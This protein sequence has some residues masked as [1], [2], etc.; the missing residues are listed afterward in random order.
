MAINTRV[1]LFIIF[2]IFSHLILP[3]Y[4]GTWI[5]KKSMP[6]KRSDISAGSFDDKI[7]IAGGCDT[8]QKCPIDLEFCFCDSVSIKTEAYLPDTDEWVTLSNMPQ[9]R[10][11]HGAAVVGKKMYLI[12]GRDINDT[13]IKVVDVYDSATNTWKS[14]DSSSDWTSATSDLVVVAV[15][16]YIY[17][18]SGYTQDYAT[19][20]TISVFDTTSQIWQPFQL[21]TMSTSRGDACA[22]VIENLIYVFGGF[23]GN[24][25]CEAL[26]SLEVFD[27]ESRIWTNKKSLDEPRG[28]AGCGVQHGEFHAIAGEKKSNVTF[29]TKYDI[30]IQ[31]VEHYHPSTNSWNEETPLEHSRFRFVSAAFGDTFYLFG[32]QGSLN[33]ASLTYPVL[34]SVEA[35]KDDSTDDAATLGVAMIMLLF[36]ITVSI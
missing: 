33:E 35:W 12:G 9:A 26:D 20:A 2:S 34:D 4:G 19:V 23:N 28:D 30:P 36:A 27:T 7:V 3:S 32:G 10:F 6:T 29:C 14:L 5:S 16:S 8:D 17:A 25:F 18:I 31:H 24:N 22:V 15:G 21:P 11:R 13:I 1:Q